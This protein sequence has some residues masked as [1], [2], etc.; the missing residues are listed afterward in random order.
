[1]TDY[2]KHLKSEYGIKTFNRKVDYIRYNFS[3]IINN[4][5]KD[6]SV[7]EIGPGMGEMVSYLND[8]GITNIDVVDNDRNVL[9]LI[10]NKY[11]VRNSYLVSDVLKIGKRLGV[12]DVIVLIQVLEHLPIVK[13]P[14]IIK[15][16]Y[17]HRKKEGSIIIVVPNANNPLGLVERYGDL[18]HT[19]SYTSQSL[20]D[21]I[22][23]SSIKKFRITISGFKIP[24]YG[25]LNII[26]IFFQK[27]LH[28][29]LLLIMVAN[30]GTFFKI[31]TPNISLKIK[32][33]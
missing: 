3:K 11:R 23:E 25:T 20:K 13:Q 4:H 32:K 2:T 18:Q 10:K 33:I 21:L 29:F 28:L 26:R 14:D 8:L 30:G 16:L 24:V 6:A 27:I 17:T 12:Y 15:I 31:M 22:V 7:L 19:I 9:T 1:M 5:A